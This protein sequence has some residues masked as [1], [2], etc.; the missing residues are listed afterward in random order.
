MNVVGVGQCAW[1]YLTISNNYPEE[2]SKQELKSWDEQGGGP[3]ATALVALARL[4][5][6]CRF[7][8]I[9]GDDDA[10]NKIRDSLVHQGIDVSSLRVREGSFSQ[11]AFIII[12][13]KDGKRT[14]FWRRP[15]GNELTQKELGE[16][17]LTGS[18]FLLL[19][20]LMKDV[21][22]F[23]A[24]TAKRLNIPVM[25]DAGRLREG[26]IELA[27]NCDYIVGSEKFAVDL[28]WRDN[29]DEFK[30]T[31]KNLGLG[32]TTITLGER[33]SFTFLKDEI[34]HVPAFNV[35]T[36]DTTGAGDVFH[37]GYIYGILKGWPIKKTLL[38]ASAMAA[39]KC[40]KIGGR[41]GI[42]SLEEVSLFLAKH[43]M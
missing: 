23:A 38:F 9:T 42:P 8:G 41:A 28:G 40:L 2:N 35:K 5:V 29:R 26:M 13:E 20:G 36:V 31:L 15:T 34:I 16:D 18:C 12:G 10:G 25:L 21:S 37:G 3:V 32:H 11:S 17:F 14:I 39:L 7:Y 33:G 27:R 30:N 43:K 24:Q 1:D 4:D 19:D 22:F 6:K